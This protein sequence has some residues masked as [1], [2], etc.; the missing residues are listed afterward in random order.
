V[1]DFIL[2]GGEDYA[3]LFTCSKNSVEELK[4]KLLKKKIEAIEIGEMIKGDGKTVFIRSNGKNEI[5]KQQGFDH[6]IRKQ[7]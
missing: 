5:L 1:Y 3:L 7:F 4:N 2:H 6:F